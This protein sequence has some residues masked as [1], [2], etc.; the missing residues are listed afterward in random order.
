MCDANSVSYLTP[1]WAD[2]RPVDERFPGVAHLLR[3]VKT[4]HGLVSVAACGSKVRL[5]GQSS[6]GSKHKCRICLRIQRA[7]ARKQQP[8]G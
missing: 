8:E 1:D 2:S 6:D 5:H 3:T 7:A 4:E